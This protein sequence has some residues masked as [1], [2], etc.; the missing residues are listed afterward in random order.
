MK[1]YL[2]AGVAMAVAVASLGAQ[3]AAPT[4]SWP[5]YNGDFS[6]RRFSPLTKI[7]A[8]NVNALTLAWMYRVNGG[9]GASNNIKSTPLMIDGVVYFTTE[10]N[11][12]AVDGRTGREVWHYTWTSSGGRHNGNKG[13]GRDGNSLFF[14]TGDC[15]L[16][17]LNKENGKLLWS[18]SI[19]DLER[20]YFASVAPV[21]VG[22][23]V[24]AGVSG[25]DSDVPGY[26]EA[27]D[28]ES[29][30]LQ[31][32]FYTVPQ[33]KGDPGM[34]TWSNEDVAAHGGGMTWVPITYD[35]DLKLIYVPTGNPQPV[36]AYANR[37]GDNLYTGS[38]VAVHADTGTMAWAFQSSPH[39]THDWDSTQTAVLIDGTING[40]PRKLLAQ[41]ARNGHFFVL[42]RTN[43][44]AIV[45]TEF[46]KTNWS[47]GYDAKG[48]P[49]P[50]PEKSPSLAGT[51]V[52]PNQGGATNW[53]PPT[54][55]PATG[56][57][58]VNA[59]RAFSV[60]YLYDGTDNPQGWGGNDR[61][62][63]SESM[64]EA[65]DYST[66]K[67]K[68]SHKWE[69]AANYGLL[70]TAGNLIFT[71]A[72]GTSI[73]ALNA[74][75]GEPLWQARLATGVSNGPTTWELDGVQY[76]I[77]GGGDTLYAFAMR[78]K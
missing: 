2:V 69:G 67:V 19:C 1:K 40:Q 57:F 46:V 49:I 28:P 56:L 21:V 35:P 5:T 4:D 34:E 76:L 68:W 38:V 62:G 77:V 20:F 75:T 50:N 16:V 18:K 70:S 72:P 15:H 44:K 33:K 25:D 59:N 65:L 45:S 37:K 6:G 8:G 52:S 60:Y 36:I 43:G 10:D 64:L 39:D 78:A 11:A 58:Y 66:G 51:L 24:I 27:H 55:S 14:E 13:M 54:F 3:T 12:F 74:T 30:E 47:L 7:N 61:G 29:G 73:E 42:D 22:N 23:H 63:W 31:W 17:S 71:G 9:G 26:L 32:R 41:A 48:Q 53:Y